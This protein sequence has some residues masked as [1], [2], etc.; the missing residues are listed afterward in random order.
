[1]QLIKDE[2]L[3][4]VNSRFDLQ[5]FVHLKVRS[6]RLEE[7]EAKIAKITGTFG[8]KVITE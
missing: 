3:E 1:M 5:C 7:I 2:Q 8:S 6:S 4:I